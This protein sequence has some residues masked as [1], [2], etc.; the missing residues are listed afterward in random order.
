MKR[1]L[2]A[3]SPLRLG[4]IRCFASIA[5][6]SFGLLLAASGCED[7]LPSELPAPAPADSSDNM[8]V[9]DGDGHQNDVYRFSRH[10]ARAYYFSDDSLTSILDAEQITG[11]GGKQVHAVVHINIPGMSSGVYEWS[12]GTIDA[13]AKSKVRIAIDTVEYVSVRG[14]TQVFFVLDP[15]TRKLFGAYEGVLESRAGKQVRLTRGRFDGGF[16]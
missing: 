16:F 1:N 9:L 11:P 3:I 15:A 8:F 2:P 14:S 13:A 10:S 5:V 7:R 12:D 4:R 6:A